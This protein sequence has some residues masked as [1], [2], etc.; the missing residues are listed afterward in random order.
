MFTRRMVCGIIAV[1]GAMASVT[2]LGAGQAYAAT[3][4][5][6]TTRAY[7]TVHGFTASIPAAGTNVSCLMAS[8]N[9]GRAVKALQ[10]TLNECYDA[11]LDADGLFGA[12]TKSALKRAQSREGQRAD[13]VYGPRTRDALHWRVAGFSCDRVDGPGGI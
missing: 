11:R 4:T 9:S 3:P 1:V 7:T 13:G 10:F 8:G 6:G 2:A 12:A 5:C